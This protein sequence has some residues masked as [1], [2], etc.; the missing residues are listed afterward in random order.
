MWLAFK[1]VFKNLPLHMLLLKPQGPLLTNS[2][3][4]VG[5]GGGGPT[6]VHILNPKKSRL[7][8]LSTPKN[9]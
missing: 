8:N 9:H 7:Q 4:G 6:E 2:N 1:L 5:G 3:D